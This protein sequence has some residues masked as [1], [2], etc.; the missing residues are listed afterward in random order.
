MDDEHK[1]PMID[2]NNI[3]KKKE[4]KPNRINLLRTKQHDTSI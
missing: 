2:K 1:I 4:E 3:P